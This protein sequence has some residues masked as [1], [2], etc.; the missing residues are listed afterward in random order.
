MIN[1]DFIERRESIT[2]R[3]QSACE[4]L[5]VY[6]LLM[7]AAFHTF[8]VVYE[9]PTLTE[10]FGN[11]YLAYRETVSRWIPRPPRGVTAS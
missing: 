1:F 2:R 9:E 11:D 8:V 10:Q 6:L 4:P 7:A 3:I 5:V